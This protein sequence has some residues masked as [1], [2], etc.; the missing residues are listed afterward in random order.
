MGLQKVV[1][2]LLVITLLLSAISVVFNL[3]IYKMNAKDY[4][5]VKPSSTSAS[6]SGNIGLFVEGNSPSPSGGQGG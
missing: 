1:M 4:K 5:N 3:M 6:N 2:V